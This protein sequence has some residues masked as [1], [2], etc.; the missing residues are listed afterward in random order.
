MEKR[1]KNV[2]PSGGNTRKMIRCMKLTLLL[3]TC[4]VLQTFAG[5]NAQIV[6]IKKQNATLEEVIWELKQ[7]TSFSFMYNDVD[8]ASIKGI[9]LNETK[10]NVEEIL[11]KCLKNTNL[12]YVVLNNAIV[13]KLKANTQDEKKS[14]TL[15]G[16]VYDKKKEPMPGV[17]VKLANTSVG[18]ATNNKG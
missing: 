9:T 13:I 15:K 12:E 14:I 2:F 8:I 6:T 4:F 10:A 11:R 7:Q 1:W 5:A 17:T 18:T 3:L 16:W